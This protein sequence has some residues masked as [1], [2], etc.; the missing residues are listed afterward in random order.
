MGSSTEHSAFDPTRNP[1]D[2]ARVPGGSSGGVGGGGGGGLAARQPRHRHR[3][4]DPPARR[5]LRRRRHEAD[6]RARVALRADRLRVLARPGR[7]LR[8][9][10]ARRGAAARRHRRPRSARRD[11]RSTRRCPT[12]R[13]RSAGGV[14][15]CASACPT[16]TSSTGWIRRSSARCARRSTC[17]KSSGARIEPVSLPHTEY[18]LA[19]YYV[20]APAEASSNLARYDGVQVRP[21]RPGAAT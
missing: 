1:W 18:A 13:P 14:E 9:G 11:R 7:P 21:A 15:G 10:R 19:A 12:T 20:I 16:S 5:V 4:L 3:R 2:L 17:S 8:P 6:L